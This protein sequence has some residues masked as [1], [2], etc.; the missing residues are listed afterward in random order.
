MWHYLPLD[1]LNCRRLIIDLPGH[2]NSAL[3]D[4]NKPS[5]DFMA[6]EIVSI[7]NKEKVDDLMWLDTVW[8]VMS[9][10]C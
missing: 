6:E 3:N 5:I 10:F 2:G 9:P 8:E 1:E 4:S 7:L